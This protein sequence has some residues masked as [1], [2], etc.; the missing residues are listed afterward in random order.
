MG[1]CPLEDALKSGD[2]EVRYP[3]QDVRDSQPDQCQGPPGRQIGIGPGIT[4]YCQ[5][6]PNW[7]PYVRHPDQ[8][9]DQRAVAQPVAVGDGLGIGQ[10]EPM[11]EFEAKERKYDEF[12]IHTTGHRPSP[13]D[14]V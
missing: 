6:D 9:A 10:P 14:S 12:Q 8:R 11:N 13:R 3:M 7:Y 4:E 1:G 5:H 2:T